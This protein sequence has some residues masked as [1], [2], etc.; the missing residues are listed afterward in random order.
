M[1]EIANAGREGVASAFVVCCAGVGIMAG[2]LA[3]LIVLAACSP[4]QLAV[5]GWRLPFLAAVV[6]GGLVSAA[7]R[8]L[9]TAYCILHTAYCILHTAYC[10]LQ[11]ADCRLQTAA[12]VREQQAHVAWAAAPA[13]SPP[14]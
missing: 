4:D 2:N 7:G 1:S 9:H 14:C 3:V 12:V 8:Q 11:T 10:I 6:N 5:W 13:R